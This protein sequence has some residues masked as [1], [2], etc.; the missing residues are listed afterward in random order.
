MKKE[1]IECIQLENGLTL[2]LFDKTRIVAGD[3]YRVV[4][5]ARIAFDLTPESFTEDLLGVGWTELRKAL[6]DQ[7][8]YKYEN[9]RNFIDENKKEPVFEDLKNQF[10]ASNLVYLSKPDFAAKLI[11]RKYHQT[12]NF[13]PSWLRI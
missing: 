9:T 4:F 11:R 8:V 2:Q 6:G 1:P 5:M 13:T 10:L 12:K 7:I 3:R